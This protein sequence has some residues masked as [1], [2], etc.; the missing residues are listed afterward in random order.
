MHQSNPRD[1][2]C[3]ERSSK[4]VPRWELEIV[5]TPALLNL[6]TGVQGGEFKLEALVLIIE[7]T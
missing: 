1:R 5:I 7:S 3:S 4:G 6:R 2:E